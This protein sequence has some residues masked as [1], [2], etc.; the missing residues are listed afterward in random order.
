[1]GPRFC[2]EG[3]NPVLAGNI[4]VFAAKRFR[5][6]NLRTTKLLAYFPYFEKNRVGL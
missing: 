3:K 1:V 4:S 5:E 6:R 2:D